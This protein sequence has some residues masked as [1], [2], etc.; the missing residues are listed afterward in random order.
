MRLA[1][2][3]APEGR[4]L[5]PRPQRQA[6]RQLAALQLAVLQLAALQLAAL[7]LAVLQLAVLLPVALR[8]AMQEQAALQPAEPP[9]PG[10]PRV[11]ARSAPH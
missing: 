10:A 5:V 11:S 8:P 7:Q 3:R 1:G 4:A 9:G 2:D 6:V